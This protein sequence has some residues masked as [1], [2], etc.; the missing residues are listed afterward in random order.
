MKTEVRLVHADDA[1]HADPVQKMMAATGVSSA[2]LALLAANNQVLGIIGLAADK[3][4]RRLEVEEEQTYAAIAR[5]VAM[6]LYNAELYQEAL[7]ANRLKSQFLANISHELRTPLN[8]IIGYSDLLLNGTYGELTDKQED[9][10]SRVNRSGNHLLML[11]GDVLDLSKIEAGQL[12]LDMGPLDVQQLIH[13]TTLGIT[14]QVEAKAL[15]LEV[16]VSPNL[17]DVEADAVR[18]RQV[19]TNLMS[20]AVKFTPE[21]F[22]ALIVEPV[23]VQNGVSTQVN[24]PQHMEVADGVW[25][26]IIVADSGIG[27]RPEDQ[28]MIFNAFQ[29]V[30]GSGNREYEGTGLGLAIAKQIIEMHEGHMWVESDEGRGSTFTA[31]LPAQVQPD[32][33]SLIEMISGSYDRPVVL[34]VDDDLPSL[35]LTQDYL[36]GDDYR[37]MCTNH[38]ERGFVLAQRH[39]PAVIVLDLMVPN[40]DGMALLQRLKE[41]PH[42]ANVPVV[43]MSVMEAKQQALDYGAHRYLA[44]PVSR[45]QLL[46]TI[47]ATVRVNQS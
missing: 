34:V 4:T 21:G 2:L 27:I 47:A 14:P 15:S 35:Q 13:D 37:V 3:I 42:T 32:P 19:L 25:L 43:V 33:Q 31:L 23:T 29:Q 8:A 24:I 45:E 5:Q 16:D 7:I 26:A 17:P 38:A 22:V 1:P 11:I 39:H 20:N 12:E 30:N 18:V 36:S 9:R 46:A 28:S 6:A 41:E 40:M 44:K 10:L